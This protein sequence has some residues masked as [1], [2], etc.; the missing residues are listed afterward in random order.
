MSAPVGKIRS[1]RRTPEQDAALWRRFR[2]ALGDSVKPSAS[3]WLKV[4]T[5]PS[6]EYDWSLFS[7]PGPLD[8]LRGEALSRGIWRTGAERYDFGVDT[9]PWKIEGASLHFQDRVHRFDWLPHLA[10]QGEN[11][12]D[13]ALWLVDEWVE[14]HGQ[15]DGFSWRAGPVADRVWNWIRCGQILFAE[16]DGEE[17]KPR[18]QA[19]RRQVMHLE[20]LADATPDV[21][22]RFRL[23]I[24]LCVMG[25]LAGDMDRL[26]S[27]LDRLDAECTAQILPDGGHVSRSPERLLRILLD[28]V[29]VRNLL[30]RIDAPEP[31]FLGKWLPRM[32]AMLNFH[33][34][35]DG[36][37]LPFNDGAEARPQDVS[38]ALS[39]LDVPPR[40]FTFSPKSGFQKLE[41]G[42]LR[43]V[44]DVGAAP[45]PPFADMAHAGAL[46][47]E[48]HDGPARI[49][50]SCGFSREVDVDMQAAVRRTGAHSTLVL[51]GRDN[52]DFATNDATGLLSPVGPD[53]ISAKRLEEEDEIW[54]DAQH[55]GYKATFGLLH[56]RRLF[57]AGDGSRLT[58]ED[59]L[60]RP[61][62]Q[63]DLSDERPIGFEIRFHLH[64]TVTA[65]MGRGAILLECESGARW[66][67]KTSHAGTRLEKSLYLSRG[68]IEHPEQIVI[69]GR[70]DPNGDGSL[71][72]NCVRWAFLRD[73]E[74]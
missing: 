47:F 59:S 13:R 67:F 68:A 62:S 71:P 7:H 26:R 14:T 11:G 60:V 8:P 41:R 6:P 45:D 34:S 35:P 46:G 2:G 73:A 70:A 36:G 63:Q 5:T 74:T 37:L 18:M 22:A 15:F 48:L 66:R 1:P 20:A 31:D 58:G 53:G 30:R 38:A 43:L 69:S 61:V 54:L 16:P 51:G 19:L 52:A 32:G 21:E 17:A 10:G 64:P 23:A 65:L 56:R 50:T 9:V 4:I 49:V 12:V 24:I 72:P 39:E 33:T 55:S 57:M 3:Q 25:G 27:G 29:S 42:S 40:R 28:L 44:L